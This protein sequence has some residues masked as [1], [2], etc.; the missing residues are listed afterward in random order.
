MLTINNLEVRFDVDAA[1][2]DDAF[3]RLFAEHIRRWSRGH[4]QERSRLRDVARERAV[5]DHD[6]G[7]QW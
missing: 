1:D 6:H 5:G 3:G 4:E 7:A 2:D